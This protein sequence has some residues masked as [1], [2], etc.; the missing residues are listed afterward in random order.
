MR[1]R[2]F[3]ARRSISARPTSNSPESAVE[4][5]SFSILRLGRGRWLGQGSMPRRYL[6]SFLVDDA[7]IGLA[8]GDVPPASCSAVASACRASTSFS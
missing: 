8:A 6:A 2:A 7:G 5:F 1:R 4:A 3:L